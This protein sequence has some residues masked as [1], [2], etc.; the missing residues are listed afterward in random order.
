MTDPSVPSALD[1]VD[2]PASH[3]SSCS[4]GNRACVRA[5][6]IPSAQSQSYKLL[7]S[8]QC[9]FPLTMSQRGGVI[10]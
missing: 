6:A 7:R 8:F 5:V 10:P 2:A 1:F 3:Q 9:K 4:A